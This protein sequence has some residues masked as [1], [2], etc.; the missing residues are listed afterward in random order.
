MTALWEYLTGTDG[1]GED[2]GSVQDK[3]KRGR[4]KFL[5]GGDVR[6]RESAGVSCKCRAAKGRGGMGAES[7][8]VEGQEGRRRCEWT[9]HLQEN[10][11]CLRVVAGCAAP[12]V[13]GTSNLCHWWWLNTGGFQTFFII[14]ILFCS[15][16]SHWRA[17]AFL[18]PL[19]LPL[20]ITKL[21]LSREPTLLAC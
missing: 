18:L 3:V 12:S 17:A 8:R 14:I 15:E 19:C 9:T 16:F 5:R 2:V 10:P 1:V 13:R 6:R 21:P 11:A 7:S 20:F 4:E